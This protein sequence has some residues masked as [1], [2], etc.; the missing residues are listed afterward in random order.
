[1]SG[2]NSPVGTATRFALLSKSKEPSKQT[3][4][5]GLLDTRLYFYAFNSTVGELV[6]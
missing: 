2:T 5:L 6:L 4:V 1:M 3:T